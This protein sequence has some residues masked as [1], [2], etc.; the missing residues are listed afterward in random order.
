MILHENTFLNGDFYENGKEAAEREA[1]LRQLLLP[2]QGPEKHGPLL[3][4]PYPGASAGSG[5]PGRM[6][7]MILCLSDIGALRHDEGQALVAV[8]H[9]AGG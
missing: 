3:R 7:G 9:G 2:E 1:L 5:A 4:Q 6:P 8:E